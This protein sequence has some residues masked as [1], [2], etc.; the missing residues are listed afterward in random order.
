M[1]L[2]IRVR[3]LISISQHLEYLPSRNYCRIY[4]RITRRV[5]RIVQSS[6][7][8]FYRHFKKR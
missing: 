3:S 7:M 8:Y 1:T 4:L 2:F 6:R 5:A